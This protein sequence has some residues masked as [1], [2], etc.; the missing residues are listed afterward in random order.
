MRSSLSRDTGKNL[1]SHCSRKVKMVAKK[2]PATILRTVFISTN[3]ATKLSHILMCWSSQ[4]TLCG[5][6]LTALYIKHSMMD[7]VAPDNIVKLP[8]VPF[9]LY[10]KQLENSFV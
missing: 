5:S 9:N 10:S 2:A 1:W 3:S 8:M 6:S 7:M 4:H